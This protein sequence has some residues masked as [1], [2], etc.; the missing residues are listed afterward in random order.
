MGS[1]PKWFYNCVKE[2]IIH[3][4]AH[5]WWQAKT[6]KQALNGDRN[7]TKAYL[8]FLNPLSLASNQP[9]YFCELIIK[10][11]IPWNSGLFNNIKQRCDPTGTKLIQRETSL[12]GKE[13]NN[14]DKVPIIK[15]PKG[16]LIQENPIN[17]KKILVIQ[18]VNAPR[19][20]VRP[21]KSYKC[22]KILWKDP[23]YPAWVCSKKW[24]SS[25]TI[26]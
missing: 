19:G 20:D 21:G 17:E 18:F 11:S 23:N 13:F 8:S 10:K 25:R 6:N 16:K 15:S 7:A 2:W 9:R 22:G 24:N 5:S 1:V 4:L 26:L 12:G 3:K 14:E